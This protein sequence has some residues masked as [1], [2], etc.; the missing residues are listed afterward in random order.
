MLLASRVYEV[1]I[2]NITIYTENIVTMKES[3]ESLPQG[4]LRIAGSA[5]LILSSFSLGHLHIHSR[6]SV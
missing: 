6:L 2:E 1:P 3:Y 5:V 4:K